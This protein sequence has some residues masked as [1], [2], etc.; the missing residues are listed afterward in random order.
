MAG[1]AVTTSFDPGLRE[2]GLTVAVQHPK[3]GE[4]VQAAV[5]VGFSE[6]PGRIGPASG[7]GE[8]N[9]A[10]LLELGYT[11]DQIE[12]LEAAKVLIPADQ[13]D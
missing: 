8:H 2:S 12:Q 10:V 4:L 11:E 3:F 5:P 6:T 1:Q 7:R 13:D 9:H